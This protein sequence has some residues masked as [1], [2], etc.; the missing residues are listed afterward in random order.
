V[1]GLVV[2]PSRGGRQPWP[3]KYGTGSVCRST[4]SPVCRR[5]WRSTT[6]SPSEEPPPS[7]SRR[8]RAAAQRRLRQRH[9]SHVPLS[10]SGPGP[11]DN[12]PSVR[13][14]RHDCCRRFSTD[15]RIG[16]QDIARIVRFEKR[17]ESSLDGH[18]RN[19]AAI[20]GVIELTDQFGLPAVAQAPN[21]STI[22][23]AAHL[24]SKNRSKPSNAI[25]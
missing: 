14:E 8:A 12:V 6:Q 2:S 24:H 21:P 1:A 5:R 20:Q 16:C 17:P 10:G 4:T 3:R 15:T 11:M 22:A 25:S 23:P 7:R 19:A 9:I 18:V 13:S